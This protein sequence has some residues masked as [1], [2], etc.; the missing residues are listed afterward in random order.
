MGCKN[1]EAH[2]A[3]IEDYLKNQ[4]KYNNNS[5]K[6]SDELQKQFDSGR[7]GFEKK[8]LGRKWH[9]HILNDS[10]LYKP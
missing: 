10:L 2:W 8:G 3:E 4:N 5:K 7:S 1:V 6:A 9:F